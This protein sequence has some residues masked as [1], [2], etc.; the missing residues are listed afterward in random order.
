[1]KILL[2]VG[3]I[4]LYIPSNTWAE[5]F[6]SIG[7][8]GSIIYSDNSPKKDASPLALEPISTLSTPKQKTNSQPSVATEPPTTESNKEAQK[9]EITYSAF[10]ITSPN[11]NSTIRENSGSVSVQLEITPKLGVESGHSISM[12]LDGKSVQQG[13]A[14]TQAVLNNLDRGSHTI[15]AHIHNSKG[16]VIRSTSSVS[17]HL[18][19]F[20]TLHNKKTTP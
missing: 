2:F 20:S 4:I 10:T 11:N 18:H 7:P 19:R 17:F 8:D 3:L 16:E 12:T 15:S 1:M 6:K 14:S 5:V 13:G 9:P